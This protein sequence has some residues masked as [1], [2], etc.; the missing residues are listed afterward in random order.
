MYIWDKEIKSNK[1][2]LIEFT[3]WTFKTYSKEYAEKF[4]TEKPL[5]L[6]DFYTKKTNIIIDDILDIF[7]KS[8][9]NVQEIFRVLE[10]VK[11]QSSINEQQST[12][13]L[14]NAYSIREIDYR[15][16]MDTIE[17]RKSE[18]KDL[19]KKT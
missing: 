3:D 9:L 15:T 1:D 7:Y 13:I 8:N 5:S 2:W 14:Y 12:A 4:I 6:D 19:W 16:I 10:G 18:Q 17:K 11:N